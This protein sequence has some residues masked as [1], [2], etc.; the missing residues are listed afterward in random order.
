MQRYD[1]EE[2]LA[3]ESK[4]KYSFGQKLK[5]FLYHVGIVTFGP[6]LCRDKYNQYM[7]VF[8]QFVKSK[9]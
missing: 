9:N 3:I 2:Q 1:I 4:K 5:A 6:I 8:D 7:Q